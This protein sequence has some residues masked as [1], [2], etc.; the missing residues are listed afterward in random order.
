MVSDVPRQVYLR[1]FPGSNMLSY[2]VLIIFIYNYTY[3]RVT[4]I[5]I[6]LS[7]IKVFV[8]LFLFCCFNVGCRQYYQSHA[9]INYLCSWK[10]SRITIIIVYGNINLFMGIWN[11]VFVTITT[12]LF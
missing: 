8:A 5:C 7:K 1:R 4:S 9:L 2:N 6:V 12:V 11:L 10:L 3:N